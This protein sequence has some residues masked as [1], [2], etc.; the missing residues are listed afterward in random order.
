MDGGWSLL[1]GEVDVTQR[2]KPSGRLFSVPHFS[3]GGRGHQ[4]LL[5]GKP[6]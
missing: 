5:L 2:G 1:H 4:G 6:V 3:L